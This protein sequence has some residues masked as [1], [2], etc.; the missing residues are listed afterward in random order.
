M[1]YN[2]WKGE[3]FKQKSSYEKKSDL[4]DVKP[5]KK[6]NLKLIKTND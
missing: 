2:F 3:P 6:L 1:A 4:S 5:S